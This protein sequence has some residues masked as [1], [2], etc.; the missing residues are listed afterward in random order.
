MTADALQQDLVSAYASLLER[1]ARRGR[2]LRA[3]TLA[4][5]A[6]LVLAGA[7]FGTAALLGWP[8]PE[9]VKKDLAAVDQGLPADLRLNPDVE[10]A[11]AVASTG[12]STL[13]AA[14]LAPGR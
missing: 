13:Y 7:A 6:V 9:H 8:A 11:R 1:R 4:C 2:Q 14:D 5:V 12:S 3:A 10:H